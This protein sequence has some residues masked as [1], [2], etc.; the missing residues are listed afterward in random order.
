MA[1][2]THLYSNFGPGGQFVTA[3]PQH[4]NTSSGN[5]FIAQ[6]MSFHAAEEGL[7]SLL[8][9]LR[10][11]DPRDDKDRIEHTKGGLL[12]DS[13]RWILDNAEFQGWQNDAERRLLW[14]RG[15]PGKGKTMLLCGLID[16]LEGMGFEPVYFFCQATDA[17]LNTATAVLRGLMY[18]LLLKMPSLIQY[19]NDKHKYARKKLFEDVNSW[20]ALRK[21]FIEML[22][23]RVQSLDNIILVIDALDECTTDLRELLDLVIV[24]SS[25]SIRVIVSSRNWP[26]IQQFMARAE[27][28]YPICL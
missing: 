21:I 18:L 6:N 28:Q 1:G 26:S 7:P 16:E 4:N 22:H 17:R 11:T 14:V 5:Q 23:Q 10:I 9:D 25:T 27:R 19:A 20:T 8:A 2:A 24:L 12:R 3:G 13:Y 15:D